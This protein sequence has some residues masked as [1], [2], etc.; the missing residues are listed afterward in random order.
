MSFM[1]EVYYKPP[2]NPTKEAALSER[3]AGL[4]GQLDY[5]E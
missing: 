3:V 1:I 5:R 2:A 4:G